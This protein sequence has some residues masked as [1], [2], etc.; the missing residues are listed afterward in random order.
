[1]VVVEA[2]FPIPEIVWLY[3]EELTTHGKCLSIYLYELTYLNFKY[4]L[5]FFP[6]AKVISQCFFVRTAPMWVFFV[7]SLVFSNIHRYIHICVCVRER[8]RDQKENIN[9]NNYNKT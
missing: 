4:G 6:I 2:M 9:A 5:K 7:C 1:M 3:F 8:E